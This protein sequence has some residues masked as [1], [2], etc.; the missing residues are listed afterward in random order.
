MPP[1]L[2]SGMSAPSHTSNWAKT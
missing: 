1:K 2:Q